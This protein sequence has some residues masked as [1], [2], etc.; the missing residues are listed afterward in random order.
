[1]ETTMSDYQHD[2]Y[3]QNPRQD[4]RQ[5][6]RYRE[7]RDE[8]VNA[9]WGWVLGACIVVLIA[10]YAMGIGRDET[11]VATNDS[12][13]ISTPAQR[14]APPAATPAPAPATPAPADA[15]R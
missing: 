5:D 1:M 14:P 4:P 10:F 15:N 7:M 8:G 2:P 9:M 12:P 6:P 3:G 11:R 13:T